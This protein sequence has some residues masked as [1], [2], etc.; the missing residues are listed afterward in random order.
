MLY[1]LA[2]PRVL[3]S[4]LVASA[5][6]SSSCKVRMVLKP[7]EP[8]LLGYLSSTDKTFL[9]HLTSVEESGQDTDLHCAAI[10]TFTLSTNGTRRGDL[11]N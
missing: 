9:A 3:V 6:I 2:H 8:L 5:V 4:L 10:F 1:R 7:G 11:H